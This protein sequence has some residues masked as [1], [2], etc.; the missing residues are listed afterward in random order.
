MP[1]L[2]WKVMTLTGSLFAG[3]SF[4]L[5][6][7]WGVLVPFGIH[8]GRFLELTLPG[9]R[10]LTPGSF[11]IG[12]VETL[13]IGAYVGVLFTVIYNAVARRVR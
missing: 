12:V 8:D 6:V 2:N 7:V 5:C 10:W 11:A 9:F 1:L 13:M 4:V 3:I